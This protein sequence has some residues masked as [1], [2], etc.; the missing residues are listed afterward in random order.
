MQRKQ[1]APR[2]SKETKEFILN[3][4]KPSIPTG[5]QHNKTTSKY[6]PHQGEQEMTRRVKQMNA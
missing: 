4:R 6:M 5:Y 1:Y 3:V 2:K